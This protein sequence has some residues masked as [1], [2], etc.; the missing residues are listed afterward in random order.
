MGAELPYLVSNKNVEELFNKIRTAKQ[1]EAFTTKFL[2]E[3]LGLT[4]STDRSLITLLKSLGFLDT[5]GKP[6]AEYGLLKNKLEAPKAIGRA[7]KVAYE[8]LFAANEKA[9]ELRGSELSGLIAQVAGTDKGMT[10]KISYTFG[11]LVKLGVFTDLA[12][13]DSPKGDEEG[14]PESEER[15]PEKPPTF[16]ALRPEF[17]YNIQVHLPSNGSE[18]VYLNIFNALRKAF[19]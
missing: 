15:P 2:N 6:T 5:S 18:E 14:K 10:S 9:Y 7:V 3:T 1:P 19:K 8:P 16:G 13:P 4:S 12:G 17:H 11:A